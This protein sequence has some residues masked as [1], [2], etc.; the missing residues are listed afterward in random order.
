MSGSTKLRG[1]MGHFQWKAQMHRFLATRGNLGL[2][3]SQCF[4]LYVA[5]FLVV[6]AQAV[7]GGKVISPSRQDVLLV[8]QPS[9]QA[10]HKENYKFS[11]YSLVHVTESQVF[12]EG[13]RSGWL[14]TWMPY[15]ELGR[16]TMHMSDLSPAYLPNWIISLLVKDAFTYLTVVALLAVFLAGSFA[17]LLTKELALSPVAALVAALALGVSPSLIYWVTF[18]MFAAAYGW[19]VAVLFG[20]ARYARQRDLL[21]WA[22]IAFS[23]YSLIMSAYPVMIMYHAY[24][25]AGFLVYL[26]LRLPGFPRG[27]RGLSVLF[28]GLASAALV[29]CM[30]AFPAVAD[31]WMATMQSARMHP[32]V[33]FLRANLAAMTSPWDWSRFVAFWTFPQVM[34]DPIA[35]DFS[36]LF[37]GR[38]LAPFVVFLLCASPWRRTWGWWLA[39]LVMVLGDA[40]VSVFA[41]GVKHLGLGISRSVPSVH[42]ILPLALIA[43][44]SMD[45][46]NTSVVRSPT[47]AAT[48]EQRARSIRLLL[49][50]VLYGL[51]LANAVAASLHMNVAVSYRTALVFAAYAPIMWV[52]LQ[53]RWIVL[54]MAVV[55]FHL[56]VFDRSELLVQSRKDIVQS[57]PLT[58]QLQHV[59]ADGSRYAVLKSAED[60]MPANVNVQMSLRSVHTYDGLSPVRYQNLISRLGGEN[61]NYGRSNLSIDAKSIASTDFMLSNIGAVVT[62]QPI[63]SPKLELAGSFNGLLMYSVKDRWGAFV[64]A[65]INQVR[66][67]GDA[68][69]LADP[70][71]MAKHAAFPVS[72]RGDDMELKLAERLDTPSVLVMSQSYHAQWDMQVRVQ[73]TWTRAHPVLVNDAYQGVLL[74]PAAEAVRSTFRPWIRWAWLGHAGFGAIALMLLA[75]RLRAGLKRGNLQRQ[76]GHTLTS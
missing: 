43:A 8:V 49:A 25:M 72:D 68:V 53:R 11:D 66:L 52:A 76:N 47:D 32:S 31:T 36:P 67:D 38:S 4:L 33:E 10:H 20:A 29:G 39:T 22:N 17:F 27:I 40:S 18:P 14:T 2:T 63:S 12:L 59:L 37:N 16:P 61:L 65:P 46:L 26:Y 73:G 51:L 44:I 30:A 35:A 9:A 64:R 50:I 3:Y 5:M 54:Y 24:L 70:S 19:T 60:F 34:G 58:T 41:F 42:V 23:I 7:A 1:S 15:N 21:S 55:L 62:R 56:G 74:P 6:F 75:M 57:S 69:T 45:A 48:D 28:A 71:A 13:R